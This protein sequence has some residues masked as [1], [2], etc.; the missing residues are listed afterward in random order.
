[1]E[2]ERED[3]V[4]NKFVQIATAMFSDDG[5]LD[6]SVLA[7]DG[8]GNVWRFNYG[9]EAWVPVPMEKKATDESD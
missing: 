9:K 6:Y 3:F 8:E 5:V 7:L 1:M 4:S 2:R